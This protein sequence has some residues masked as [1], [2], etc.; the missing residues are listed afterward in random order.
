VRISCA[1][2]NSGSRTNLHFSLFTAAAVKPI[3][4]FQRILL[5]PLH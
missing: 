4:P 5:P 3:H 1:L 2:T